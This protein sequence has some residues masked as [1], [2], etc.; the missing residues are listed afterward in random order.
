[1][2]GALITYHDN[3]LDNVAAITSETAAYFASTY[4]L[5]YVNESTGSLDIDAMKRKAEIPL[6][7]L[8][9]GRPFVI[10]ADTDIVFKSD[11]PSDFVTEFTSSMS[12]LIPQEVG[13]ETSFFIAYNTEEVKSILSMWAETIPQ[14]SYAGDQVAFINL[15]TK[16]RWIVRHLYPI[17]SM[18]VSSTLNNIDPL[19]G[20]HFYSTT[21]SPTLNQME[22]Y[23]RQVFHPV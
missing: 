21:S 18:Y 13:W 3:R 4:G 1:M 20:K 5:D 23:K 12:M 16:N 9:A 8:N 7:E 19:L 15:I 17:T 6:R 14:R 22:N 11:L 2:N 10:W